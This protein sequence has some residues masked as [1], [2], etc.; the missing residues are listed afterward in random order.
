MNERRAAYMLRKNK[1]VTFNGKLYRPD[2][3]QPNSIY[4]SIQ[5]EAIDAWDAEYK[6]AATGRTTRIFFK[7]IRDRL[8][9]VSFK[10]DFYVTQVLTGHGDF[11]AYLS[12]FGLR[13]GGPCDCDG[14]S[15][16]D[17]EHFLLKCPKYEAQRVAL[18][19]ACGN[20]E[21]PETA[22]SLVSNKSFEVF[23]NFCSECLWLREE[24]QKAVN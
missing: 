15:Q 5:D 3:E 16:D 10:T 23:A 13:D 6:A 21:W 11:N 20:D 24:E 14:E 9:C 8:D 19:D 2:P 4:R 12:R 22:R 1:E 17:I 7:S 18:L